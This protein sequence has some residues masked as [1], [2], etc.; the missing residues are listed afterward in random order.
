MNK[1]NISGFIIVSILFVSA[2]TIQIELE[3][4]SFFNDKVELKIPKEF[5]IMS[6][7]RIKVKYPSEN[8]P[9][10]IYTDTTGGINVALNLTSSKASQGLI[11]SYKDYL[12]KAMKDQYPT[13]KWKSDGVADI[14][15]RKVA[16]L[17]LITPGVD[18]K[19][20][21]LMFFTDVD[22]K[23]LLCTFNC[24]KSSLEEWAPTAK[25]IMYSLK[26]K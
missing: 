2:I 18:T 23:L 15:G 17:E 16:Y 10:L 20:Y 14:N 8:R 21:N 12:L 26:V 6:E 1:L 7:E 22:G 25:E 19:I 24:T 4:K 3:T 9:T 5:Q 11:P 13:A